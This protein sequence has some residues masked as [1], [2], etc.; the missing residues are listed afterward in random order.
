M[1]RESPLSGWRGVGGE[2][3]KEN[4][5]KTERKRILDSGR[6]RKTLVKSSLLTSLMRIVVTT[7]E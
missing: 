6:V 7:L 3:E 2:V 4:R 1:L 5:T